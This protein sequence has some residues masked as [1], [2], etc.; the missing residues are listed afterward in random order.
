MLLNQANLA[1][2]GAAVDEPRYYAFDHIHVGPK[3]TTACD[4][5]LMIRVGPPCPIKNPSSKGTDRPRL[6]P[7]KDAKILAKLLS[8]SK[9]AAMNAEKMAVVT[10]RGLTFKNGSTVR[11]EGSSKVPNERSADKTIAA[12]RNRWPDVDE[13]VPDPEREPGIT[14]SLNVDLL[15]KICR[16]AKAAGCKALRVSVPE[17]ESTPVLFQGRND[18]GQEFTALQASLEAPRSTSPIEKPF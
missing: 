10:R 7:L 2:C 15:M 11:F 3:G 13:I 12:R 1:V 5:K 14:T 17:A 16:A 4:G 9:E 8:G 18:A 6:I